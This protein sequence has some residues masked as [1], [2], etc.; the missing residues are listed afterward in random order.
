MLYQEL[1]QA[2]ERQ[3]GHGSPDVWTQKH[4][5]GLSEEIQEKTGQYLSS[6]TLR[7]VFGKLPNPSEKEYLPQLAT[8]DILCQYV[9]WTPWLKSLKEKPSEEEKSD[10]SPKPLH[11]GL[12]NGKKRFT[13]ILLFAFLLLGLSYY[14]EKAF[15][16]PQLV[17]IEMAGT[18]PF[19]VLYRVKAPYIGHHK[20]EVLM[21][22]TQAEG[23]SEIVHKPIHSL[24]DP[25]TLL[26][27][28]P[29]IYKAILVVDGQKTDSLSSLIYSQSWF[30]YFQQDKVHYP[31]QVF[32]PD[33]GGMSLHFLKEKMPDTSRMFH[34]YHAYYDSTGLD[35]EDFTAEVRFLCNKSMGGQRWYNSRFKVFGSRHNLEVEVMDNHNKNN[36]LEIRHFFGELSLS[37]ISSDQR[38]CLVDMDQLVHIKIHNK[39]KKVKVWINGKLVLTQTYKEPLGTIAGLG[40]KTKGRARLLEASL[41]DSSGKRK[42]ELHNP[43]IISQ[44]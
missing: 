36:Y 16:K 33:S 19:R 6:H 10:F 26:Y 24:K 34:A 37:G 22:R 11:T 8:L 28:F 15:Y 18:A 14:L 23:V 40:L 39:G 29:G 31:A 42:I 1:R 38:A 13:L 35:S 7:R 4:F 2:V 3:F 30:G 44:Q 12:S 32:H 21:A 25:A 43:L 27:E 20:V 9:G 17:G 41:S 5:V